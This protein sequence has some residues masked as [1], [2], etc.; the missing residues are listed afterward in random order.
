MVAAFEIVPG[1]RQPVVRFSGDQAAAAAHFWATCCLARGA[2]FRVIE[3][4]GE[5]F[6]TKRPGDIHGLGGLFTERCAECGR[7][8]RTRRVGAAWCPGCELMQERW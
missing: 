1:Y 5:E 3:D 2:S 6:G 7:E 8:F 4:T